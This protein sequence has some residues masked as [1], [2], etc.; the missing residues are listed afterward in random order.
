MNSPFISVII[1][2]YNVAALV[3]RCI[4]SL[5]DQKFSDFEI[6]A[7]DDGSTDD[8]LSVLSD[9]TVCEPRLRVISQHNSGAS[10]ARNRGLAEATG[11]WVTFID[12]DDYVSFDYLLDFITMVNR[13][14]AD[15]VFQG[16]TINDVRSGAVI[17][18]AYKA[19]VFDVQSGIVK[20]RSLHRGYSWG[21]LYRMDIIKENDI[22]FDTAITYKE[23]LIFQLSY[24]NHVNLIAAT[25]A[26]GYVY[27][28]RAESLSTKLYQP[29]YLMDINDIVLN[30]Q[31]LKRLDASVD[32]LV[33]IAEYKTFC[34]A[35]TIDA[36]YR[37]SLSREFRKRTF[38]RL[39]DQVGSAP[40]PK[41]F[42]MDIIQSVFYNMGMFGFFDVIEQKLRK[43]R[44]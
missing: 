44:K 37:N 43:L 30:S 22:N 38:R 39:L 13:H 14:N 16:A 17:N 40:Y 10:A 32:A 27:E 5:S 3:E 36:I 12:S 9:L 21:K 41:K 15:L 18:E 25:D 8:T 1:P 31:I 19:G 4:R 34:I 26:V 28:R 33:Y 6:I 2:C 24:L 7:V 35:E 29:D 20:C 11:R 23:D 42:K